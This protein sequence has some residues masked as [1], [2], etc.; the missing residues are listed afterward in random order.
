VAR[1]G[2]SDARADAPDRA[3]DPLGRQDGRQPACRSIASPFVRGRS[4]NR[5]NTGVTPTICGTRTSER[6]PP[7]GPFEWS[8]ATTL[9]PMRSSRDAWTGGLR[10]CGKQGLV[11]R[12]DRHH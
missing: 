3:P 2:R 8:A 1:D 7:S 10:T 4:G 6:S 5:S 12:E 11:V 9:Q